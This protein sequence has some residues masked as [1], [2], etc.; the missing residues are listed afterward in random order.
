MGLYPAGA[1]F[2]VHQHDH[3][4][5][6]LHYDLRLQINETS[7][8]S[9]AVTYG[10]PGDLNFVR[11]NRNATET[12]TH[13]LWNHLVETASIETG[14]LLI[15]D[16]GT[17]TV[18]SLTS[19]HAP[20]ADP[21]SPHHPSPHEAPRTRRQLLH[22]AFQVRNVRLQLHGHMFTE[23]YVLSLRLTKAEGAQGR[24]TNSVETM[25]RGP[26]PHQRPERRLIYP[27][28]CSWR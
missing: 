27:F 2:V 8:V 16:T 10:L 17:Y 5:A 14:S 23:P 21:S 15:W 11:L 25:E 1:H 20:R 7:S 22:D 28:P 9:W 12:R 26:R 6:G 18:L 4:A 24:S 3:P 19:K 13:C